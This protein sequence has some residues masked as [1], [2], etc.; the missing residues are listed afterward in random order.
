MLLLWLKQA[1]IT[2]FSLVSYGVKRWNV[3]FTARYVE[4]GEYYTIND[5]RWGEYKDWSPMEHDIHRG[6]L[7]FTEI[8][9]H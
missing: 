4:W 2:T 9:R 5:F 8:E 7:V 6:I 3:I 1:F